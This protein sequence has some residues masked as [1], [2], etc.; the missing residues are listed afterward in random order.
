M[1]RKISI[2]VQLGWMGVLAALGVSAQ[3]WM[4]CGQTG[5]TAVGS[6]SWESASTTLDDYE[7]V[8]GANKINGATAITAMGADLF[9]G[10]YGE[11]TVG[12]SNR[13]WV[14]RKSSDGGA[15]WTTVDDYEYPGSTDAYHN[16]GSLVAMGTNLY[17]AGLAS[18]GVYRWVVRK[19]TD[20]G[21]TWTTVDDYRLATGTAAYAMSMTVSGSTLLVAGVAY[22]TAGVSN[23][24][25]VVRRSTDEGTTWATVD[26][27]V[28]AADKSSAAT[29]IVADGSTV[30]AVG[31]GG[32]ASEMT[33]WVTRKSSDGGSTWVTVNDFDYS[34]GAVGIAPGE[35]AP[36]AVAVAGSTVYAVGSWNSS[37]WLVRKSTDSGDTWTTVDDY[38]YMPSTAYGGNSVVSIVAVGSTVYVLGEGTESPGTAQHWLL[39]RSEDQG[40]TWSVVDDFRYV[41][42][43]SLS[44]MNLFAAKGA[45]YSVGSA[46]DTTSTPNEHWLVQR[47]SCVD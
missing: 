35:T 11:D 4:G 25:W 5:G 29:G 9:V 36:T 40:S 14:V 30:Y 16:L 23:G 7:R 31:S 22:D 32:I 3:A 17:A 18:D 43:A 21:V 13:H 26:D 45:V 39:R 20:A 19:S 10:G 47:L 38:Q 41:G 42:H 15:T 33:H 28:Y 1:A 12:S 2:R 27:Y 34:I 37:H 44:P 8:A 46:M 24:H 6:C